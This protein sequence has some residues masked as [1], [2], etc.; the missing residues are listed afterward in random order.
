MYSE[1]KLASDWEAGENTEQACESWVEHHR[2]LLS[3]ND[4]GT[5]NSNL[6]WLDQSVCMFVILIDSAN[7]TNLREFMWL[8]QC[9][10]VSC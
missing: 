4:R 2:G 8:G 5:S 10:C 6:E 7:F 3:Q 1:E 9:V